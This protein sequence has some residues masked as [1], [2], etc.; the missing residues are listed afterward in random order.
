MSKLVVAALHQG[1]SGAVEWRNDRVIRDNSRN[2]DLQGWTAFAIK[3]ELINFVR[4]GGLVEQVLET[5]PE[6]RDQY[7]FYD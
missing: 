3:A 2:R 4:L 7:R 5:R 1:L 6:W